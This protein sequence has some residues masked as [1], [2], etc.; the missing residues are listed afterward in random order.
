ME[1]RTHARFG[2]DAEM[3]RG[4]NGTTFPA[5]RLW[6][7]QSVSSREFPPYTTLF[8]QGNPPR[9]VFH[10]ERGLVKLMRLS[11]GGQEL[12]VGLQSQGCLL[13]AASA[14]VK[15]PYPFTAITITSCALSRIPADLFLQLAR[16]DEQFCWYLHEVH[17]REVHQQA[18]QL[19]ALKYLSARQRFERLLLQFL[20]SIP[21]HEKQT[22]MKVRLPL[23]HWEIAQL[24]GV[25]PEHL[26]R[27]LQQVKRE[28]VLREEDGCMIVSDVRKL[29]NH[30]SCD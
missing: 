19:A 1:T 17:S 23:K 24:I 4:L 10:I 11:A 25:R 30:D 9:E 22:S 7:P 15:E 6:R 12:A 28:G 5:H 14:I 8:L 18:S 16:T 27:I 20:S 3:G 29:S 2:M 21:P 26:S 13:G